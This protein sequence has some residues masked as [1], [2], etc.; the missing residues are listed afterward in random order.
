MTIVVRLTVVFTLNNHL[1]SQ[2]PVVSTRAKAGNQRIELT[3]AASSRVWRPYSCLLVLIDSILLSC[4]SYLH[5]ARMMAVE[6]IGREALS[7]VK[8]EIVK[9]HTHT[10]CIC[11]GLY[12]LLTA[13]S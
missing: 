4:N 6:V 11:E 10:S 3:S 12:G 13:L 2:E 8:A 5:S 7:H 9:K 1:S